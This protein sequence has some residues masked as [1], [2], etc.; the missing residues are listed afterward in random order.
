MIAGK[1]D[2]SVSESLNRGAEAA[3]GRYLVFLSEEAEVLPDWISPLVALVSDDARVGAVGPNLILPNGQVYSAGQIVLHDKRSKD[4]LTFRGIVS[5]QTVDGSEDEKPRIVQ[6]LDSSCLLIRRTAFEDVGGFDRKFHIWGY[7]FDL[8][9]KLQKRGWLAVCQ[10][11]STVFRFVNRYAP[12][13]VQRAQADLH[14]M[15]AKWQAKIRPDFVAEQDGTVKKGEAGIIREY[16]SPHNRLP[17]G[18]PLKTGNMGDH[19]S[20]VILT[21]NEIEYTK[22]CVES[23]RRHTPEPHEIIFVDNGSKDGTLQWLRELVKEN[24]GYRL[25]EKVRR[26]HSQAHA[27][28]PRNHLRRQRVQGRNG[29]MAEKARQ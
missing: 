11:A 18:M 13:Q 24:T 27:G 8:L 5:T 21:F 7:H 23:I 25:I 22:Q 4:P 16:V 19:V 29:Q 12:E 28:A 3:N 1:K 15:H 26:E 17:S 2:E 14:R 9:F 6:V 20:I 10:P